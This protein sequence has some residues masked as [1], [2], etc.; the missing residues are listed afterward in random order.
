MLANHA[1]LHGQ[2]LL[3]IV[4]V[5]EPLGQVRNMSL[6]S[7]RL[8][9]VLEQIFHQVVELF[10]EVLQDRRVVVFRNVLLDELGFTLISSL[11]LLH[12]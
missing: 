10:L 2:I 11:A 9:Q 8:R 6:V 7:P 5:I 3:V 1:H 12:L 4:V